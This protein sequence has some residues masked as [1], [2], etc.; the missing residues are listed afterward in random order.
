MRSTCDG[1]GRISRSLSGEEQHL[2]ALIHLLPGVSCA[3]KCWGPRDES[4]LHTALPKPLVCW[5]R[6]AWA[7]TIQGDQ[8]QVEGDTEAV[9]ASRGNLLL[10]ALKGKALQMSLNRASPFPANAGDLRE[11]GPFLA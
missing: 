6:L 5:G 8:S 3:G 10:V 9:G 2:S 4:I 1:S 11:P 7:V